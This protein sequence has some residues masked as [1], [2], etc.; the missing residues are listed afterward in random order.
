M[1][2]HIITLIWN[3]K[4]S[5]AWIFVEQALVFGVILL[6]FTSNVE[7]IK[8]FHSKGNIRMDHVALIAC[9][10]FDQ[11]QQ[12]DDEREVTRVQ[13]RNML[14]RMKEWSS[15]DLISFS[16]NS[17]IPYSNDA[18]FDSISYQERRYKAAIKYCDENYYKILSLKLTEG[19]WFRDA[20]IS[21]TPPILVT[22]KLVEQIGLNGNILGQNIYFNGR[23]YRITG[24]VEAFK[25]RPHQ[26]Q[27]AAVFIPLSI[28]TNTDQDCIVK[29]KQGKGSEFF[30]A[31]IAEFYKNFQRDQILPLVLDFDKTTGMIDFFNYSFQLY[32]FGIP[33]VF[34]LIFA[35][36]GTFGVVW[37]QSKKRMSELGLRVALG[38]TPA[39]LQLTIIFENLML[40][41]FAMLPG[42]IVVANLYAFSPQG[43]EWI[44]AVGAAIVLMW[45][46]AAFSAWYPARQA[47][48]V[49]PVDAL[50]ANQ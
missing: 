40:T 18:R 13:F 42:I 33:T 45:L 9:A 14:E 39:R 35:F 6:S 47:A 32:F 15:V 2:R 11:S 19:E 29:F 7:K 21:E 25:Q 34:L 41:T 44:T 31:F 49:Q 43:W 50:R 3:R 48:K 37:M 10:T 16:S 46:F 38:C 28:S 26:E 24:V 23:T 5:L 4:R 36:M 20:D 22:Q 12:T 27:L 30:K 17:A 8:Q 1:I